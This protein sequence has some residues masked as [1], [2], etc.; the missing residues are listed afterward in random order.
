MSNKRM[1]EIYCDIGYEMTIKRFSLSNL[2]PKFR[3]LF[4]CHWLQMDALNFQKNEKIT[5]HTE[6]LD[7]T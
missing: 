7:T 5:Y 2:K 6:E 3:V 4:T 1:H